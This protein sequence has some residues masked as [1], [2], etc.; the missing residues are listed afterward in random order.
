PVS[1][2]RSSA[3]GY[4]QAVSRLDS[5]GRSSEFVA[6][7]ALNGAV[8]LPQFGSAMLCSC[9]I[10]PRPDLTRLAKV[11]L[12]PQLV[13][14]GG[15]ECWISDLLVERGEIA[16]PDAVEILGF[17]GIVKAI[18]DGFQRGHLGELHVAIGAQQLVARDDLGQFRRKVEGGDFC[19]NFLTEGALC[20]HPEHLLHRVRLLSDPARPLTFA[21]LGQTEAGD[22]FL[23][24]RARYAKL[25]FPDREQRRQPF[26]DLVANMG[27]GRA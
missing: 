27:K 20:F 9:K 15:P 3:I 19:A 23:D 22:H 14:D 13:C 1:R 7:V 17:Q 5:M 16:R 2:P 25:I 26:A 6:G 4:R 12:I 18:N 10:G 11:T 24:G 8:A 21:A